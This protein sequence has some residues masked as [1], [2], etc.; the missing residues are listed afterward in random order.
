MKETPEA[1]GNAT[2]AA[3]KDLEVLDTLLAQLNAYLEGFIRSLPNIA[4]ALVLLLLTW[5]IVT[6]G[7]RMLRNALRR[8]RIRRALIDLSRT[9]LS[10]V[11]WGLGIMIAMTVLFPSVKPSSILTAL[12]VGGIAIGFAFKDIFENFMAG[13]MIMLRKPMR[14]GDHVKCDSVEGK[15]EEILIRDTYVRQTDGQ[16]VLVPNSMLYKNPVYIR[17]DNELRR[18]DITAGVAYDVD[19]EFARETITEAITGLEVVSGER[20][21][22]VFVMEFNSS[23]VDF[24]VRWWS[25]S[26][27]RD[28]HKSR[29]LVLSAIKKA[30][31]DADIEIPFPYRTLTFKEPLPIASGTEQGHPN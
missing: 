11:I 10:V 17:T 9:L 23:S 20:P 19:I 24:N 8:T 14:I 22:D 13:A 5:G 29:D 2:G 18:Y 25:R 15:I 28:M 21:V 26:E 3:L 31:D 1:E 6:L 27:P 4:L 12:G 16:L 30:L 7:T